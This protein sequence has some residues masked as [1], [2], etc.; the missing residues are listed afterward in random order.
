MERQL[1]KRIVSLVREI[2]QRGQARFRFDAAAIV[3]VHYWSV[4][5]DRPVSWACDPRN[6]PAY[7]RRQ[8]LPSQSTMSRRLAS[9]AIRTLLDELE[10]RI[11]RAN[12]PGGVLWFIDGKSL[13][14]GGCSKDRQA[15]YG[16]AA[17]CMAK[18]YKLHALVGRDGTPIAWRLAPMNKDERVHGAPALAG[19]R[20]S[21]L[22]PR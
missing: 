14:I 19:R 16:R 17:G 22:R 2:V 10:K 12:G 15:G 1:L 9:P 7:E 20:S 4:I 5:C 13:P 11:V 3:R 18:G 8:R 6:W 21:R